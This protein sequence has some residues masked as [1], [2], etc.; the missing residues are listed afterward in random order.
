MSTRNPNPDLSPDVAAIVTEVN[1]TTTKAGL[2]G[3]LLA[4]AI[5]HEKPELEDRQS[6][7]LEQ[8][9]NLK[10]Q[11]VKLEDELLEELAT[12]E[13]NLLENKQL[14]DSLARTKESSIT[15]AQS[16]E[17]SQRLQQDLTE[18]R[19]AFLPLAK[20]ASKI[21]FIIT[22]LHR[23]NNM[24]KFS[25]SSFLRL[26]QR[27]LGHE[28]SFFSTKKMFSFSRL[29]YCEKNLV[30]WELVNFVIGRI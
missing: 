24:Y 30:A 11:L 12:A 21:Y 28:V 20:R 29:K 27:A 25:L 5:K 8:E 16:L 23:I 26:F 10:L 9:E 13:G 6:Q 15:I 4:T 3:Q 17:E 2:E 7:L 14:I 22:D 1:F 18:E 19:N